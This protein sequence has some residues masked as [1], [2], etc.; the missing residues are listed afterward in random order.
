MPGPGSYGPMMFADAATLTIDL[1]A[2]AANYRLLRDMAPGAETAPVVKANGYGLG[3][4]EVARRLWAEGARSFYVARLAEG[5]SLRLAL[6]DRSARILVF[7]GATEGSVE[8]LLTADLIPVLNSLEQVDRWRAASG[9]T[10]RV[11]ALHVD[12]GMNRLGLSPDEARALASDAVRRQG[13]AISLIL[14]HLACAGQPDHA[15][16]AR[17]LAAFASVRALFPQARASLASSGGVFLGPDYHFDQT[18]PG[19]SLYGGG[20]HDGPDHRLV[21]VVRLDVPILQVRNIAAG[22][23]VGYGAAFVAETP[24]Q[25]AIISA[26]YADGILRA[27]YPKGGAWFAGARRALLGRVSMDLI[28]VDITGAPGAAPGARVEL[29]GPDLSVDDVAAAAGTSAY[30]VLVRL[31]DR[32]DRHWTTAG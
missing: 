2:V 30:E 14:S 11:A 20:P 18:R 27:G 5:E 22:D 6:G 16:N 1:D 25:V 31:G 4:A 7:D 24:M 15:M 3:A 8:R 13:L 9:A 19:I 28:A 12:T 10:D 26:G 21:P 32:I 23:S 29:I 17:Q